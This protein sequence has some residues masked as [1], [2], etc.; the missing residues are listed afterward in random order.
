MNIFFLDKDPKTAAAYH[1][2]KHVVKMET[3]YAQLLSTALHVSGST[4]NSY[5]YK[6]THENHPCSIWARQSLAHW[7]FLWL[8]GHHV[9]NEFTTRYGKIH[10]ATRTIRNLPVPNRI[11][12]KGWLCNPP[13]AMPEEYKCENAVEAYRAYYLKDKSRFATWKFT[14][15]PPWWK[16]DNVTSLI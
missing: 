7:K 9:G 1:C 2:D 4:T 11:P 8:L 10:K 12:N 6:P 15:A 5:T 14:D 13:L 16:E 3:E